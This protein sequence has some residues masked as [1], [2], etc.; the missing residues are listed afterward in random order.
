MYGICSNCRIDTFILE[1]C[2]KSVD[3]FIATSHNL[4]ILKRLWGVGYPIFI[5]VCIKGALLLAFM[6]NNSYKTYIFRIKV[7][8]M[9]MVC[10]F[11]KEDP[12]GSMS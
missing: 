5:E 10:L 7:G 3:D 1:P 9:H 2:K 12:G 4:E 11:H 8:N 6:G